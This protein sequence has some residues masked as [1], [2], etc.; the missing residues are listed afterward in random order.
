MKRPPLPLSPTIA[1]A[2]WLLAVVALLATA[3]NYGNNL[4][5]ALAFLLLSIWLQTAWNCWRNLADLRW[6]ANLPAPTF[7]GSLLLVEGQ[8]GDPQG[9]R[10]TDITLCSARHQGSAGALTANGETM[11]TLHLPTDRR[12][13]LLIANLGLS[14]VYPLGL[15]QSHRPL[16]AIEALIYPAAAGDI[17]L[18]TDSPQPAH[19]QAAADDFQGVVGYAPGDSPRRINWRIF[20]RSDTLMVNRFDGSQ[21]GNALWLAWENCLGD[22]E[23]RLAQL[24]RWVLDAE[25]AGREYGLRLPGSSLPAGRGRAHR[26]K[27]LARLALF[28]LDSVEHKP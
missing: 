15:W 28:S 17:P 4:I 10:R 2:F 22:R 6:Q 27:C 11:L 3:I 19:R 20:S 21:G 24:T 13:P 23:I 7:A 8:V 16:P 18:P 14:S 12:G 25:H 1:G 9:R 5:F 26:E